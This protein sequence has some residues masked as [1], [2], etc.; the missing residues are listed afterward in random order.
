MTTVSRYLLILM[1]AL[2]LICGV[3]LHPQM[4]GTAEAQTA[5][6]VLAGPTIATGGSYTCAII[7][8]GTV[9]CWGYNRFGQLGNGTTVD[10]ATPM[11]VTRLSG[12]ATALSTSGG[13][14]CVLIEDGSVE[15]WGI[16]SHGE[17]GARPGNHSSTPVTIT[18]LSGPA[19]AVSA[20]G[21]HTCVLI[22]DGSVQ[23]WGRNDEGQLGDGTTR[24][25]TKPVTVRGLGGTA[26]AVTAGGKHTCALIDGGDIRCWGSNYNGQLGN[27]RADDSTQPVKVRGIPGTAVTV[28]AGFGHTCALINDGSV[29]CWGHN[30]YAELGDGTKND[31]N[32]PVAVRNLRRPATSVVAGPTET[33]AIIGDG[34]VQCWGLHLYSLGN[35]TDHFSPS[36]VTATLVNGTATVVTTSGETE[37]GSCVLMDSGEV[38]CWGANHNGAQSTVPVTITGLA[39]PVLQPGTAPSPSESSPPLADLSSMLD[40]SPSR[41]GTGLIA[42]LTILGASAA[43]VGYLNSTGL[44]RI[45]AIQ[46]PPLPR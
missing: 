23:C 25:S 4:S 7:T 35:G 8:D 30:Y 44:F 22:N 33:C 18:G 10:S 29:R 36:P 17:L 13:H 42:I 34:S 32:T 31:S 19:T 15:C 6:V 40:T 41:G 38:Q 21:G 24:D 14:T 27:G 11:T 45:P 9:Q 12:P 3:T 39:G 28:S 16:N 26:V 20:G 2:A 5:G 46:L 43:L 37:G 1:A